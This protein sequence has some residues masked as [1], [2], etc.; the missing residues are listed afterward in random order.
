MTPEEEHNYEEAL[1][2]HQG[3]RR[4]QK[5]WVRSWRTYI[6]NSLPPEL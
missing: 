3:S 1:P 4:Q 5:C 2:A 6:S